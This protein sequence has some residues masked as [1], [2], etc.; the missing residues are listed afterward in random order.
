MKTTSHNPVE[1]IDQQHYKKR[2]LARKQQEEEA[3]DAI[4]QFNYKEISRGEEEQTMPDPPP[5]V[6]KRQ[7]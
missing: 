3:E 5:M 2:Y 6:E 7:L 4:R 1:P